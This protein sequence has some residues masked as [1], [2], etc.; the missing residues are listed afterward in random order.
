MHFPCSELW[1]FQW[2]VYRIVE[3]TPG[4]L[5][6]F[7]TI[8]CSAM[9]QFMLVRLVSYNLLISRWL[10]TQQRDF[11]F[12]IKGLL[13]HCFFVGFLFQ[14]SEDSSD[15]PTST[16]LNTPARVL[17]ALVGILET[18]PFQPVDGWWLFPFSGQTWFQQKSKKMAGNIASHMWF[19]YYV[20]VFKI[21]KYNIS[22]TQY[23]YIYII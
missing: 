8:W 16:A 21:P 9:K 12:E 23:I 5:Y 14:K 1:N 10:M 17:L 11:G 2:F 6:R 19:I 13:N 15:E 20:C 18:W 22:I 4:L 7:S 3:G